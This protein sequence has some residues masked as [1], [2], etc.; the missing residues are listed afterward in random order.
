MILRHSHFIFVE[1]L[2]V[3]QI[4]NLGCYNRPRSTK[5]ESVRTMKMHIEFSASADFEYRGVSP[6]D[7]IGRGEQIRQLYMVLMRSLN[8][9]CIQILAYSS[10]A[11]ADEKGK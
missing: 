3:V 10:D 9:D 2:T 6:E 8:A 5:L 7:L 1:L 4:R 11:R